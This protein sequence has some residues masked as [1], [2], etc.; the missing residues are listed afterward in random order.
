MKHLKRQFRKTCIHAFAPVAIAFLLSGCGSAGSSS[1]GGT[2]LVVVSTVPAAKA[3]NVALSACPTGVNNASGCGVYTVNFNEPVDMNTLSLQI[4]PPLNAYLIRC[5]SAP[6]NVG[7]CP[8]STP[9]NSSATVMFVGAN[10][11]ASDTTYTVTVVAAATPNP[12]VV[13]LSK[14]YEW[15]FTTAG[16]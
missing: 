3:T 9:P 12:N 2:A 7:G 4:T 8:D 16:S 1:G 5:P 6:A 15:T 14:T 11:F 13:H 10:S